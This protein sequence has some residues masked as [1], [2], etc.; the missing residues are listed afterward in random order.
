MLPHRNAGFTLLEIF[1]ALAIGVMIIMLSVPS[2]S[3]LLA[4]QRLKRSFERLDALVSTARVRS[5]SEQRGYALVWDRE[6]ITLVAEKRAESGGTPETPEE[7]LV[8]EDEESFELRRPAAL[9]KTPPDEWIFWSNGICEP[10]EILYQGSNGKWLVRYDPL[11][12]RGIFVES[13]IP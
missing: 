2:I 11:T 4:E 8:F 6:G 9:M 10:A 12:A 13:E 1:L 3:G 7:R 5:T